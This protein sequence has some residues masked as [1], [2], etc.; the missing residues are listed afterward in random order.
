MPLGPTPFFGTT[1][2]FAMHRVTVTFDLVFDLRRVPGSRLYGRRSLFSFTADGETHRELRIQG[3]P[4]LQVGDTITALLRRKRDWR[5]LVGWVNHDSGEIVAPLPTRTLYR[6]LGL[7]LGVGLLVLVLWSML[8]IEVER[9][10]LRNWS[11]LLW[12]GYLGFLASLV[13]AMLL[14]QWRHR[15]VEQALQ[16]FLLELRADRIASSIP[17]APPAAPVESPPAPIDRSR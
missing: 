11:W 13:V 16:D 12:A 1:C 2:F 6:S 8:T 15:R 14:R 7:A 4:R 5:T 17:P 9:T 10:M 3:W